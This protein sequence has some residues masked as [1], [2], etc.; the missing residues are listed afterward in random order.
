M[1]V[2]TAKRTVQGAQVDGHPPAEPEP[3]GVPRGGHRMS[4]A[5][6]PTT[7]NDGFRTH[8]LT[9]DRGHD[10]SE[11]QM[12]P[13]RLA[14]EITEGITTST[15]KNAPTNVATRAPRGVTFIILPSIPLSS[16]ASDPCSGTFGLAVSRESAR[17]GH[18]MG[19]GAGPH[20]MRRTRG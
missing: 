17:L 19:P 4:T 13:S 7:A 2:E 15:M 5:H 14:S 3:I 16:G 9:A 18:E 8:G 20:R 10:E 6:L 11:K 1:G 12:A